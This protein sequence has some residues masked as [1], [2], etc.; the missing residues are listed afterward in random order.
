MSRAAI[1]FLEPKQ[2]AELFRRETLNSL[3]GVDDGVGEAGLGNLPLVDLLLQGPLDNKTINEARL[4]LAVAMDSRHG[5]QIS[6]WIPIDIEK[7]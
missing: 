1:S 2:I 3:L 4:L 7:N 5:L 6:G